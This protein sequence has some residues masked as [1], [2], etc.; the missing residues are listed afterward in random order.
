MTVQP[1]LRAQPTAETILRR[2]VEV[3]RVEAEALDLLARSLDAS[4]V[5]ACDAILNVSGRVVVTGMGKSGHIGR[6]WAA[7][8]AAT[9][10]LPLRELADDMAL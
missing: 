2:G 10:L 6:K 9:V 8:M 1:I 5:D 4:F 3:V 7:T